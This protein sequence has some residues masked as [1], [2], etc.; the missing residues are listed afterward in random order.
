MET[1]TVQLLQRF[2]PGLKD[3]RSEFVGCAGIYS[4]AKAERVLGWKPQHQWKRMAAES[5]M[6]QKQP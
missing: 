4:T 2:Y 6:S 5:E 3:L 1:P